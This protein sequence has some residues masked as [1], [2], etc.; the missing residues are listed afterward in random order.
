MAKIRVLN[1]DGSEPGDQAAMERHFEKNGLPFV[2]MSHDE[3][4]RSDVLDVVFPN[5]GLRLAWSWDQAEVVYRT[6]GE[7]LKR[8]GRIEEVD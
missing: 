2:L 4:S 5:S 6:L 1:F 8:Q 3:D 7:H